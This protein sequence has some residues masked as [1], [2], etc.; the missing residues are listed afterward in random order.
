MNTPNKLTIVRMAM[1]PVFLFFLLMPAIPHHFLITAVVFALASLTDMIDGKLARRNNQI[2]SFGKFLDPLADKIMITCALIGFVSLDLIS[3]WFAV[4]ILVREFLVTSLRLVASGQGK[5]IAANF[6]GKMK[7][8][9]QIAAILVILLVEEAVSLHLLEPGFLPNLI[10][11][12]AI[13]IA[14]LFTIVSGIQYLILYKE[15]ID[16]KS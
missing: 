6:W 16:Y 3:P 10:N 2:T 1:S 9:S 15:Y 7:T 12:I 5:V 13:A 4:I 11:T 8:V 14:T